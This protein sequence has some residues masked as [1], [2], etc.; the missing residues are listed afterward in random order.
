MLW[1]HCS[2]SPFEGATNRVPALAKDPVVI[3][4]KWTCPTCSTNYFACWNSAV[5]QGGIDEPTPKFAIDLS[6]YETFNDEPARAPVDE[7]WH[8]CLDDAQDNQNV[9]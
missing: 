8:L 2:I 1:E 3:G 9:L 5:W 6:Y 7:P 4:T